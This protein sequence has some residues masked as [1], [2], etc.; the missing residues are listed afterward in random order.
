MAMSEIVEKTARGGEPTSNSFVGDPNRNPLY[1]S[2]D[3]DG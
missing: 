1:N 3:R 2:R